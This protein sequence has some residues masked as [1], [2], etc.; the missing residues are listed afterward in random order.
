MYAIVL[1]QSSIYQVLLN[2]MTDR[3][4][5]MWNTFE[6]QKVRTYLALGVSVVLGT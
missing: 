6:S 1:M 3:Y 2:I 4:C 5:Y